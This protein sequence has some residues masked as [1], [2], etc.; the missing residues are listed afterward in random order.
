MVTGDHLARIGQA[1]RDQEDGASGRVSDLPWSSQFSIRRSAIRLNSRS[2][3]V[4][5]T[6]S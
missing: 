5:G 6:R 1:R 2:L 4:T 3:S